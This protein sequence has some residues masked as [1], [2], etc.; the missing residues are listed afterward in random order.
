MSEAEWIKSQRGAFPFALSAVT[1]GLTQ[2]A[3]EAQYRAGGG[4]IGHAQWAEVYQAAWQAAGWREDVRTTPLHWQ[5]PER[6]FTET[7][8]YIDWTS[9]Y[10]FKAVVEYYNLDT[11]HWEQKWIQAG[12]DELPTHAEWRAEALRRMK[13]EDLSPRVRSFEEI[14]WVTEETWQRKGR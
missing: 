13:E 9:K 10:N 7:G 2:S 11:E 14:R 3:S 5:I 4:E 1:R 8:K 12:F 6:M